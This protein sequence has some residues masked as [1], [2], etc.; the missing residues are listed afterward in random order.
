MAVATS[1]A[2]LLGAAATAGGAVYSAKQS[3]K[4]AEKAQALRQKGLDEQKAI[5]DKQDKLTA[6]RTAR[7]DAAATERRAR[8]SQGKKGLLFEGDET[9][10]APTDVLGG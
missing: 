2:L 8:L 3:K 1:T 4:Q 5:R 9:G 10:V 7:A 6:E